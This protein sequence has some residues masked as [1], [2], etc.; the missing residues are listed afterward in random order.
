MRHKMKNNKTTNLKG[1]LKSFLVDLG[2]A[3]GIVLIINGFLV[4]NLRV[5]GKSM[6]PL[7]NNG[8]Y[9]IINKMIYHFKTPERGDIIG[10]HSPQLNHKVVKRVIGLPGDYID[11]REE[12][13]YV[14]E[15][16]VHTLDDS[17]ILTKG[18]IKYPYHVPENAYFVMGDNYNYSIDS[19]FNFIGAV[20]Q[21]E[22]IG[23]IDFRIWPFWE[24]A[25]LK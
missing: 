24:N 19:R 12:M 17:P 10:F 22:I 16:P 13:L 6:F 2:I 11:F 20:K 1:Y 5:Q 15:I 3:L 18:D 25:F 23:R 8:D 14:N 21:D 7:L 9:V 4:Q